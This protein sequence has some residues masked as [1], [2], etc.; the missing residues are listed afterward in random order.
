MSKPISGARRFGIS[1]AAGIVAGCASALL[2]ATWPVAL[3][4]VFITTASI[5]SIW[6]LRTLW[7]MD[8]EQTRA[9]AR[10]E[11]VND[12]L[13]DLV[14]MITLCASLGSIGILLFSAHGDH[15]IGYAGLALLGIFSV[16]WML[17][18]MYGARYARI[19]Y[20]DPY[21][22]IDF[23]SDDS[24][25]YVDFYY[26]SFN[27]GMTYQVSDTSVNSS[28]VRSEVLRHCL[29]SYVY[30]TVIIACTINL[31]LDLIGS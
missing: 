6:G 11:D 31:V 18:T 8:G 16:W 3:L 13:A 22:G 17:N 1:V 15:K 26:F 10:T 23:N 20:Q 5:S 2:G 25:R 24:P 19:Y 29:F 27:L 4:L 21:G 7:P 14:M 30:G 9:Y 28:K 12:D